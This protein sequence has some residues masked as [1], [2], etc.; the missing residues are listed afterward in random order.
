[1]NYMEQL[2]TQ[3]LEEELRRRKEKHN[4]KVGAVVV[5]LDW[6][7]MTALRRQLDEFIDPTPF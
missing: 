6:D 4:V 2:S 1:M 3:D 5:A 7:E